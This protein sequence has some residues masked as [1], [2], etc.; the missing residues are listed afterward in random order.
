MSKKKKDENLES[1][2]NYDEIV[3]FED[4]TLSLELDDNT[5]VE[6]EIKRK[7]DKLADGTEILRDEEE[8]E[9]EQLTDKDLRK[10]LEF[11]TG[12]KA[13]LI[14]DKDLEEIRGNEEELERLI[15]VSIAKSK[16]F[17]YQPK[18]HF[19]VKYRKERAKKNR[20]TSVSRKANFQHAQKSKLSKRY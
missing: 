9:E 3:K 12:V 10:I 2:E 5:V 6:D 17:K 11:T 7:I 18:K 16:S 15:R 13:H 20:Q 14:T 19:G 4:E 1:Q 8:E